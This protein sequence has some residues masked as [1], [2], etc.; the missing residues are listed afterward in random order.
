MTDWR[1]SVLQ[2]VCV[3]SGREQQ[4]KLSLSLCSSLSP[5]LCLAEW[6]W[7]MAWPCYATSVS[8]L[9]A[10]RIRSWLV[11]VLL[12]GLWSSGA[13]AGLYSVSD[14]VLV[15]DSDSVSRVFHSSSALIVEFYATW[16]GH[17]ASFA[18]VWKK[19]ARDVSGRHNTP[20]T[21]W[22]DTHTHDWMPLVVAVGG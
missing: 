6:S 11:L 8:G 2:A 4:P 21:H 10:L 5:S 3:Y 16:C 12:A 19:L 15:L 17:C 20:Q 13:R 9:G 1:V 14:Q 7:I 18:P 22:T